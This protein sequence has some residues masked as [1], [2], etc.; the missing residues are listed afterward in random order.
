MRLY[1]DRNGNPTSLLTLMRMD[2]VRAATQIDDLV[3]S[4]LSELLD[5][6][7]KESCMGN[8]G[9]QYTDVEEPGTCGCRTCT[10][11]RISDKL[12]EM[13]R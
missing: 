7:D 4:V 6:I 13:V 1:R 8:D 9:P 11:H 12:F 5:E 10:L 3:G 2:P